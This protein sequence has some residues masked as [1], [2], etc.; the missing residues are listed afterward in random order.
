MVGGVGRRHR[1]SAVSRY[2]ASLRTGARNGK[3]ESGSSGN[4]SRNACG[5]TTA[6]ERQCS[7]SAAAFSST[8]MLR[9][10]PSRRARPASSIAAARPAG[11]APTISTSSSIRSPAP[12]EPTGRI[13]R[14]SGS[15]GW[16]CAGIT[17]PVL[18]MQFL[19]LFREPRDHLEQISHDPVIG[20]LEDRRVL[21][22]VDRDDHLRGAHA[23]EV[24]DR[25]GD[26]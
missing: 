6:P 7:P 5:L 9:A 24:L 8:P 2:T 26:P 16:Y 10:G 21:V 3:S 13:S 22:L 1:L 19:D 17:F 4:S 11:P 15:G 12:E 20:H 23:G 14:S 18:H 25:A